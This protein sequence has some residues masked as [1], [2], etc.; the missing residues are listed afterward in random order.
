[1]RTLPILLLCAGSALAAPLQ[2]H[3]LVERLR[4]PMSLA[5]AP[6]GDVYVVE[7][8][9]RLLRIRPNTGGVFEIGNLPVSALRAIE[10]KSN[11]AVEDGLQGIAI[12]PGFAK[13]RRIYLYYSHP[14][15]LLDRLSRFTI[16]NGKLD[17]KSELVLIDV[18]SER[19]D[20]IC[21]HGGSVQFGPDGLLYL[22]IGDNTNPFESD[23][24]API[25]NR[26]N[27][28][29]WDA[30]RSAGNTNDLRGKIL[31]IRPTANGYEI[32][33][34]N[35]F[36]KGTPKTRPEIYVMGCRNPFRISIDP[37][38]STLYWGEVGPDAAKDTDK[39]PSGHDE[40]NQA[41]SAGNFG[42]PFLVANNKPYPIVDFTSGKPGKM[43]DP[44]AP[45]NSGIRNTGLSTLPAAQ[46]AFIWYPYD[47]SKEFPAMGKGGRNAMAGP[48]FYHNPKRKYNI[49]PKEDDHTLL[50]YDWVRAKVWKAELGEGERLEKLEV[51]DDLTKHPMDLEMAADGSLWLLDYGTEWWFNKNGSVA[52]I[53]PESANRPPQI[54]IEPV[55]DKNL[56]FRVKSVSDPENN[57]VRITWWLTTGTSERILGTG[58]SVKVP[59]GTGSEVRAVAADGKSPPSVAR[60]SLVKEKI[61]PELTLKLEKNPGSVAFGEEVAFKIT[62]EAVPEAKPDA[63]QVAVRTRYIPATGHDAGGPVLRPEINSLVT[64]NQCLACHQ[65]DASSV[66]PQYLNVALKY[67]GQEE[68]LSRLKTKLKEGGNGV[69]GEVPM[70]PQVALKDEDADKILRAILGLAD[71]IS[72]TK[73]TLDGKI[74]LAPKPEQTDPGGAWEFSATAPG[75][76]TAKFR[77]PAK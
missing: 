68:A 30:Q 38:N 28:V 7:R 24:Y 76:T 13:N 72:E 10:P 20:R 39:G 15:K 16:K 62:S 21:H 51:L 37:K 31:R 5:I 61:D 25:D 3:T 48:V 8:E 40:V 6:D 56:T 66:G 52:R 55:P 17:L 43:T 41:K 70:P 47:E 42:W 67:R 77:I 29:P 44:A 19:H 75:F 46:S 63:A 71:G 69:W 22:S 9:G 49:L 53:L 18:P 59:A 58:N 74:T 14:E 57:P 2:K 27:R 32:P 36:P 73:G 60:I 11:S 4:D 23:G 50:T 45:E 35:L 33:P 34:G 64:A 1:M 54:E 12:D 65:V 26:E